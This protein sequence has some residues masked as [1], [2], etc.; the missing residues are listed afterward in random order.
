[1]DELQKS[2]RRTLAWFSLFEFA[3]TS[4]EVWK[5]LMDPDRAY[6]LEEVDLFLRD[7]YP[8]ADGV[9]A[10]PG[11]DAPALA[12]VR[13]ER[14]AHA[15]R[16][17]RALARAARYLRLVPG[18]RSVAGANTLAFMHTREESDIDLFVRTAPG[19]LW[20]ARLLCVAPFALMRRRPEDGARDPLCFS[21]FATTGTDVSAA[22]L[23]DGDPY[24][25]VWERSLMPVADG[26][27]QAIGTWFERFAKAFQLRRLPAPLAA[28]MNRDTRVVVDD[29]MLKF[30]ENDRRAEYRDRWMALCRSLQC[31]S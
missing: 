6:T 19:A 21:F 28:L 3:P 16:K 25:A 31:E 4:F 9:Y 30:H 7:I 18:V 8:A 27:V 13:R 23:P 2:I 1:M 11:S 17:R 20:S 26:N 15:M 29:T 5:W 12:R 14:R 10:L 24:L 22:T